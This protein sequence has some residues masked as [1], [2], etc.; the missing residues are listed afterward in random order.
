M[1]GRWTEPVAG[2]GPNIDSLY[3]YYLKHY[4]LF[5]DDEALEMFSVLYQGKL[6]CLAQIVGK[7]IVLVI[8]LSFIDRSNQ[9]F[10]ARSKMVRG[11]RFE[12][13]KSI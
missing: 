10:E 3:E 12:S 5:G 11:S 4:I 8:S 13:R 7:L 6:L 9:I 1:S 2:I